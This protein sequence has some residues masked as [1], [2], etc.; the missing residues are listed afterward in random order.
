M[1]GNQ[2][3]NQTL[4]QQLAQALMLEQVQFTKK[5]LLDNNNSPY[6]Q[7]FVQQIYRHS[8]RILLKD[9]IQ[10]EQ[11][12]QVVIKYAFELNLGAE[13]L[14]FIGLVAQK[15]HHLAVNTPTTFNDLLSDES[16]DL[17]QDKIL[18]L[19]QL[20]HYIQ[21]YLEKNT[22][23]QAVS[24]QL[25]NQILESNTPW[26]DQLRKLKTNDKSIRS[27]LLGFVQEQQ[28]NIELKLEHQLAQAI[29]KQLG[30]L[31]TLPNEELAEISQHIWAD[32]KTQK[33][34]DSFSQLDAID[35]EEFFILVYETW[36]E[37]RQTEHIQSIVLHV[38]AAF[39]ESFADYDLQ[40]LLQAVGLSESDLHEEAQRFAPYAFKA[41]DQAEILDTFIL[42]LI[43]PFY[44]AESTLEI[45][46]KQLDQ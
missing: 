16:Y 33:V 30:L 5:Q 39:Y 19:E 29:I 4:A 3:S 43:E 40:S 13:I 36:K 20:R 15:I 26:L 25:A 6:L 11:L 10:L 23:I 7:H 1:D 24:L 9:I 45:I 35:V 32:I 34:R 46:Q 17:W 12:N 31:I 41:L 14:E 28:Q 38:V 37:L 18:E 8:N 22:K 44:G 27:K 21:N 2:V 42:A